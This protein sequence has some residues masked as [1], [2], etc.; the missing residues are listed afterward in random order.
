MP[1]S[2][3]ESQTR[4]RWSRREEKSTGSMQVILRG[5]CDRKRLTRLSL[6]LASR[7][8][9]CRKNK[10][11]ST[12]VSF[13]N[14]SLDPP[15][16]WVYLHQ[17]S[18]TKVYASSFANLVVKSRA[19]HKTNN[20]PIPHDFNQVIAKQICDKIPEFCIS[21][22]PPT[23]AEMAR[24][25][26]IA[27]AR[28]INQKSPVV[29]HEVFRERLSICEVCPLFGGIRVLGLIGCGRCGCTSLKLYDPASVCPLPEPRWKAVS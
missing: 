16:G 14:P 13:R 20:F 24:E 12:M 29:S 19:F 23:L 10:I 26:A 8:W 21:S 1:R 9:R 7:S 15:G 18:S 4:T 6:R 3:Y 5:R 11:T 2:C 22:E 27:A 28:W 17:E 25:F